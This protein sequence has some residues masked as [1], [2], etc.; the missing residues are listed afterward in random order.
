MTTFTAVLLAGGWALGETP[1][2]V[3]LA[4]ASGAAFAAIAVG[5]MANAFACRS[6]SRPAATAPWIESGALRYVNRAAIAVGVKP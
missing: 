5:Q 1:S 3:L 6:T 2:D 4:S